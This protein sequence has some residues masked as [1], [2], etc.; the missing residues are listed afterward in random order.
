MTLIT[1]DDEGTQRGSTY[2][3]VGE[4]M[5]TL[6]N[7]NPTLPPPNPPTHPLH[8]TAVPSPTAAMLLVSLGACGRYA[9]T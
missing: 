7:N 6:T 5:H 2:G 3:A 1:V 9:S 4:T 8:Q